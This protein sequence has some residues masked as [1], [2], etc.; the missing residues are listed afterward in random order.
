MFDPAR[1]H[2][3]LEA[4]LDQVM[5]MQERR[6]LEQMLLT[7]A[8][9]RREFWRA[10]QLHAAAREWA[11]GLV[12]ESL[13][14]EQIAPRQRLAW[15]SRWW[16]PAFATAAVIAA[17]IALVSMARR[18][19]GAAPLADVYSVETPPAPSADEPV[20]LLAAS[21]LAVWH[22][23]GDAPAPGTPLAPG[24]LRIESGLARLDFYTGARVLVQGPAEIELISPLD[25][26]L[27][28]G[29]IHVHT[30]PAARGFTVRASGEV[31]EE[32]GTDFGVIAEAP[33]AL[34]VH[35]FEGRVRVRPPAAGDAGAKG[36][37]KGRALK[38]AGS[39]WM[40]V[41]LDRGA[42]PDLAAFNESVRTQRKSRQAAWLESAQ[43]F[44][45]QP[46]VLVHYTFEEAAREEGTLYN[47][48]P[49]ATSETHGTIV[50]GEWAEGRWPG[51]SALAFTRV[52]D[53]LRFVIPETLETATF[54]AWLRVDALPNMF[55]GVLMADVWQPGVAHMQIDHF[56]RLRFG[57]RTDRRDMRNPDISGLTEWDVAISPPV[58]TTERLGAWTHVA[59]VF[60]SAQLKIEHFVDGRSVK[61]HRMARPFPLK[62]G[63]VQI[64]N[65]SH[66]SGG[67]SENYIRNLAGRIDEFAVLER[68]LSAEEIAAHYAE[69]RATPQ[70]Q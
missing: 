39:G 37:E 25:I 16:I 8:E 59:T 14:Q 26:A 34:E 6:E 17:L 46:G 31:I 13:A 64:G 67:R 42:F 15:L 52:S 35:V 2:T 3:L 65:S 21:V 57:V 11:L 33:S 23:A 63:A 61:V 32:R 66:I 48:S 69:G 47:F 18:P 53:R 55:N 43:A 36:I 1:L 38:R 20:A 70:G 4:Y 28:R 12:G 30:P 58:F 49:T 40:P 45:S 54:I 50:G 60:D 44:A 19:N 29:R 22:E 62:L 27:E 7:S 5:T 56:G 24:K 41:A 9:A 51:K 10:T 68:A